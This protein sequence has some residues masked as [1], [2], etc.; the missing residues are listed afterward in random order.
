MTTF[1]KSTDNSQQLG[2]AGA[3]LYVQSD[4][5]FNGKVYQSN[6]QGYYNLQ[7]GDVTSLQNVKPNAQITQGYS[8]VSIGM[9]TM[10]SVN[11]GYSNTAL[12]NYAMF[13]ATTA[14][15][16][17]ALGT[18]SMYL[19]TTGKN[20]VS[21]GGNAGQS[22]T[23]GSDNTNIG[24]QTMF[25]G[26]NGNASQNTC[27]GSQTGWYINGNCNVAV[28]YNAGGGM[29]GNNNTVIGSNSN[30]SAGV[31]NSTAIGYGASVTTSNQ[32]MLGTV[33]ESV[34]I[35]GSLATQG[36]VY[37]A[38]SAVGGTANAYTLNYA[39]GGVYYIA[40]GINPSANSTLTIT[41]IPTSA[42]QSYTLTVVSYQASTRYYI[43][44]VKVQDTASTYILGSS[45]AFAAPL[46]NGG[47]P[48]LTGTTACIIVQ[49]FT[50]FS[51]NGS[52]YVMSSISACT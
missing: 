41:N 6:A 14:Y 26:S 39:T 27:V 37:E 21:M 19:L 42:G 51:M 8:N 23:T 30:C 15:Q 34:V 11:T 49:Q 31:N 2:V 9:A 35:P 22:I 17:T 25:S 12:G 20:N 1:V 24:Q 33:T 48:S 50:V 13:N 4:V 45:G 46:F 29:T 5:T 43:N 28:G 38:T 7:Y 40:S 16:N 18:G 47:T 52:R 32:I 44:Q 36:L 3:P 10:P